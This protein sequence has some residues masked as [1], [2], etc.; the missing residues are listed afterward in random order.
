M[1]LRPSLLTPP[2]F[3]SNVV[4]CAQRRARAQM[5]V[6]MSAAEATEGQ[7]R[8]VAEAAAKREHDHK[9]AMQA[10]A[11]IPDVVRQANAGQP[12]GHHTFS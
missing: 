4:V 7:A 2:L 3:D 11:T 12:S 5:Q 8:R 1:K 6:S 10:A 9:K